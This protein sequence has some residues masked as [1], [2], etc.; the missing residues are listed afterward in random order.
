[1]QASGSIPSSAIETVTEAY[2]VARY[3]PGGDAAVER[4]KQAV[5]AIA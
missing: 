2:M 1:V 3:G 4:L 5:Q